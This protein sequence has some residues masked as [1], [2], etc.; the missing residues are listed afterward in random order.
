MAAA[1]AVAAVP[2]SESESESSA[3]DTADAADDDDDDNDDDDAEAETA[4]GCDWTGGSVDGCTCRTDCTCGELMVA[5]SLMTI[6]DVHIKSRTAGELIHGIRLP[7]GHEHSACMCSNTPMDNSW[8]VATW[9]CISSAAE[10]G[11]FARSAEIKVD[12]RIAA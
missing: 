6:I 4:D 8:P 10:R 2:M 3:T 9:R 1:A 7:S 11:D 5:G 12:S